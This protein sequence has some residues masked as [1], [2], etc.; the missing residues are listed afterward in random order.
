M[1]FVDPFRNRAWF[2]LGDVFEGHNQ[3]T[4]Q[5][6]KRTRRNR[7]GAVLSVELLLVLPILWIIC[8]GLVEIS[9]LLMGMQRVQAAGSAACR[10]GTLPA[11]NPAAQEQAMRNAAARALEKQA[12]ADAYSMQF[13]LGQYAGDPVVVEISV[14]MTAV[15]PDLLKVIGFSLQGRQLVAQAVMCKQ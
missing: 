4:M 8:F 3:I 5:R 15:S 12:L 10:V 11:A 7:K 6:H 13:D 2:V 14:P 9:L 1:V